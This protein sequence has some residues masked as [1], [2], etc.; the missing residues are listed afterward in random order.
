MK[1]TK[2]GKGWHKEPVRHGLAAKGVKTRKEK[3]SQFGGYSGLAKISDEL[4]TAYGAYGEEHRI[5]DFYGTW[6]N[7][8][9]VDAKEAIKNLAGVIERY[10][11]Y[12]PDEVGPALADASEEIDAIRF[13]REG[14]VAI[15]L[16]LQPGVKPDEFHHKLE[17]VFDHYGAAWPDEFDTDYYEVIGPD[18]KL[19]PFVKNWPTPGLV[20][21]WWD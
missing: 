6:I 11:A 7:I 18:N 20:R 21:M 15:Y 13:A 10:N 1:M 4:A 17:E 2:D 16:R 9:D 12:D 8:A 14:S 19:V 3:L 5:L